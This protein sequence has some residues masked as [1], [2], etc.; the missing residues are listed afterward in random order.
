SLASRYG[1]RRVVFAALVLLA[2]AFLGLAWAPTYWISFA[3]FALVGIGSG[4]TIIP[5]LGIISAWFGPSRRGIGTGIALAGPSL[6][7]V[8]TGIFVPQLLAQDPAEGWRTAWLIFGGVTLVVAV[9]VGVGLRDR[10]SNLGLDPVGGSIARPAGVGRGLRAV[11][12]IRP[13][14]TIS[15]VYACFGVAYVVYMTFLPSYLQDEM[16]LDPGVTQR[17]WILIGLAALVGPSFFGWV[18]DRIGRRYGLALLLFS[19]ALAL[20]SLVMLPIESAPI[21]SAIA[22]GFVT[23][24][25][26]GVASAACGDYAGPVLASAAIGFATTFLGIGQAIGPKVAGPIADATGS[27]VPSLVAS[28]G[29]SLLGALL[30]LFLPRPARRNAAVPAESANVVT[31]WEASMSSLDPATSSGGLPEPEAQTPPDREW[32]DWAGDTVTREAGLGGDLSEWAART[33]DVDLAETLEI[34]AARARDRAY[35]LRRSLPPD[36]ARAGSRVG[37]FHLPWPDS[38]SDADRLDLLLGMPSPYGAILPPTPESPEASLLA[39]LR[40]SEEETAQL[41]AEQRDRL[42][43]QADQGRIRYVEASPSEAVASGEA[44]WKVIRPAGEDGLSLTRV[45]QRPGTALRLPPAPAERLVIWQDGQGACRP[46]DDEGVQIGPG[47]VA[48]VGAGVNVEIVVL[49]DWPAT[50][51]IVSGAPVAAAG[52]GAGVETAPEGSRGPS[53]P[54]QLLRSVNGPAPE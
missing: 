8:L 21:V 34:A 39:Q 28:A 37:A 7:F 46:L 15:A 38:G 10:P 43:P 24:A 33:P 47:Q 9:I 25:V 2:L 54:P 12:K 40:R 29:V 42:R 30:A 41:L 11:L 49:G 16:G 36:L 32:A 44:F 27:F 13:L 18:S 48:Q 5:S 35:R 20:T 17:S 4:M 45:A 52:Q 50:Y 31:P 6:C 14:W 1:P 53:A 26:V 22:Y 3:F 19:L 23:V 51:Y